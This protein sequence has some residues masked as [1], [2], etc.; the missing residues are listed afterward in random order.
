MQQAKPPPSAAQ[1]EL[2]KL[3]NDLS[4]RQQVLFKDLQKLKESDQE[5]AYQALSAKLFTEFWPKY[6]ALIKKSKGGVQV[7]ARLAA[8]Q[9]VQMGNKPALA[10]QL[11]ADMIRENRDLPESAQL[12]MSLRYSVYD[13]AKKSKALSQIL[14]LAKSKNVTV[15]AA[16]LYA[17]AEI[18]KDTNAKASVPLYRQVLAKYPTTEYAKQAKGAIF[19]AENLQVGMVAPE[20][21]GPDHED[22]TFKLSEYRG[23]VVI[24][25]FWG[26][27]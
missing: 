24:L 4:Q 15:Q 25:D 21:T 22:K 12:A 18:T 9:I 8:L 7:R 17:Q 13:P 14:A 6:K 5:K 10:D 2:E 1:A 3:Q 23:K 19:E 11:V 20:I 16:A 27:W 26:F